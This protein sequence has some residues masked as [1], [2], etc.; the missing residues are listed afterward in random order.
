MR[1]KR[2]SQS[3]II[4][5]CSLQII[6]QILPNYW[7]IREYKPD[8][9]L[10]LSIELFEKNIDDNLSF[11]T[12][13]EHL[14][15]Q[16]KGVE[17]IEFA[18]LKTFERKNIEN[19]PLEER[20]IVHQIEV[21]KFNIDTNELFTVHRMGNT[22]PVLLFLVDISTN[23]IYYLCLNDYIEKVLLPQEPDFFFKQQESKTIYVPKVNLITI[24]KESL[25]AIYFYA[26]RPK[27]YSFFNKIG[28]QTN[29]LNYCLEESLI[30]RCKYYIS[31]LLRFDVWDNNCWAILDYYKQMLTLINKTGEISNGFANSF[32]P[33][34][35][36]KEWEYG[37]HGNLYTQKE[38]FDFMHIHSLW[39]QMN[40]LKNT[41]E[42]ICREW[43]LP[44]YNSQ[45]DINVSD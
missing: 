39:E 10:D 42:S 18:T 1:P 35:V 11:D 27:L 22:I 34:N 30:D 21:I 9:G 7:T 2:K 14:F 25:N 4:E 24:Q 12:L 16:V 33:D 32:T 8:Y 5:N 43:N 3:H 19:F 38:V 36:E 15:V 44:L 45:F 40:S 17:K 23:N 28:C 6:K 29:E 31:I 37:S 20:G 13:G 41:Y 26:K